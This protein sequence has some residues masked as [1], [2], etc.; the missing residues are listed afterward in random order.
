MGHGDTDLGRKVLGTFLRKSIA[1]TDLE[2]IALYNEGVK[3]ATRDSPVATEL[4]MLHDRGVDVL[5]C[6]TCV[7]HYGLRGKLCVEKI[8]TMDEIVDAL[9]KADKVITL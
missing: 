8:G 1:I 5:P 7:D 4:T 2:T 9:K 3:L 6:A